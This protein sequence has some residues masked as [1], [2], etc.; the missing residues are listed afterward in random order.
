MLLPDKP[1][2]SPGL[3]R[4]MDTRKH[5]ENTIHKKRK[6]KNSKEWKR[7]EGKGERSSLLISINVNLK[8]TYV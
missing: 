2:T 3:W 7:R 5:V 6:E 4:R 8:C 1:L